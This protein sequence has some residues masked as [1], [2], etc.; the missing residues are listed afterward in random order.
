VPQVVIEDPILNSAFAEPS[1]HFC[2]TEEGI[3]NEIVEKRRASSYFIPIA[4]PKK[5]GRQLQF[6][7]EWTSD[8]LEENRA[9][10]CSRCTTL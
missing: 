2:F 4:Q 1:Q 8:R 5:K 6:E 7:T 3:T 9:T 10:R